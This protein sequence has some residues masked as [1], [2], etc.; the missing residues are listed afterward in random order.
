MFVTNW[1]S[2][3]KIQKISEIT[4]FFRHYFLSRTEVNNNISANSI[5]V[6]DGYTPTIFFDF[7]DYINKICNDSVI[8]DEFSNQLR[9]T[10]LFKCHTPQY[11]SAFKGIL[12]IN[13]YSGITTSDPSSNRLSNPKIYTRWYNATH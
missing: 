2:T 13:H 12:P 4:N 9:K 3:T 8:L 5:Q 1:N 7:E 6:M 11:Y 10:I